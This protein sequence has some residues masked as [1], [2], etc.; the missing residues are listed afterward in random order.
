M[1]VVHVHFTQEWVSYG[2]ACRSLAHEPI[3]RLDVH[4]GTIERVRAGGCSDYR[5]TREYRKTCAKSPTYVELYLA[6]QEPL[7][8]K[9]T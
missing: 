7:E 4:G 5:E 9:G 8:S 2:C 6:H 1:C 3:A